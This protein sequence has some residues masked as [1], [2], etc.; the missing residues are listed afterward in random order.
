MLMYLRT[1]ILESSAQTVVNTVNTV[2]VMGKGL[3]A[4]FKRRYPTMFKEY[5][6]LCMDGRLEV[7]KLWLWRGE[8]Q[9]V[10]NFPTKKHWRNPSRLSYIDAGLQKFVSAYEQQGITEISFPRLGCGNGGLDWANVRPLMESYLSRLT[11]PVYIHDHEKDIGVPEHLAKVDVAAR[12]SFQEFLNDLHSSVAKNDGRFSTLANQSPFEAALEPETGLEIRRNRRKSIVPEQELY[13]LWQQL[14]MG[15]VYRSRMTG[16]A[17]EEA[18]Y[19]IPILAS[20]GYIRPIYVGFLNDSER[21]GVQLI[22]DASVSSL[23]EKKQSELFP[24]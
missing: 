18:Y 14:Q 15:P 3:A 23:T 12:L 10:L 5:R 1:S 7:G 9:W 17:Y 4:E 6:T 16:T 13:E 24:Q 19:L 11:I 21:I 8:P 22:Q 2:G 20:L